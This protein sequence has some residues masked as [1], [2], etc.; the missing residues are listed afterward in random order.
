M[1]LWHIEDIELFFKT[2]DSCKGNVY[3]VG[4][5]IRLNLKSKLAQ[6]FGL[7]RIFTDTEIPE[8]ELEFEE[9]TDSMKMLNFACQG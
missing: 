6:Y 7:A 5:D 1:K 4:N 3:L 9:P 2:V 8:L